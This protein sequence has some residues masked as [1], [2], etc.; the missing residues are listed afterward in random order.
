MKEFK[1]GIMNED[2]VE[3]SMLQ[4]HKILKQLK[5]TYGHATRNILERK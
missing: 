4:S 2:G 1:I 3:R 5:V